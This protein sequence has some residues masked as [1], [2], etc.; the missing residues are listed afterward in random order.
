MSGSWVLM[1]LCGSNAT[2]NGD[3]SG[4]VSGRGDI[5]SVGLSDIVSS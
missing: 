5:S 4:H 2:D 1:G 3:S